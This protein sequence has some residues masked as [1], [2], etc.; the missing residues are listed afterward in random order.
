MFKEKVNARTDGRTDAR[1][2][3]GHDISSLA[4]ASGANNTFKNNVK[5]EENDKGLTFAV[6][7]KVE[8][9]FKQDFCPLFF[10]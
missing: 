5:K 8:G 9:A 2:T 1:R 4:F 10:F 6:W 3:T 7:K